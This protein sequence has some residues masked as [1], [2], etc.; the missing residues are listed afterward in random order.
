[1]LVKYNTKELDQMARLMRAE[2]QSEG[3][4]GMQMVGNVVVNRVLANCDIFSDVRSINDA[5]NQSPG[6]FSGINSPLYFISATEREKRIAK[7]CLNGE[8]QHPATNSLWFYAPSMDVP[9]DKLFYSQELAGRY[10]K[11]CFYKPS[12][13]E[14]P[15][16][17][18]QE[19]VL[20]LLYF[21]SE[22]NDTMISTLFK[23]D[24]KFY[25]SNYLL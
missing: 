7:K 20:M 6:G 17:Y 23:I 10:K 11:H 14:C 12:A 3:E 5:I 25:G 18:W 19:K 9:C 8:R 1:M 21:L 13:S 4:L 16:V 2:A 15:E 24:T 22:R